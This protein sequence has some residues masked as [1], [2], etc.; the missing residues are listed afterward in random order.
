[1]AQVIIYQNPSAPNVV[2]CYPTGEI[3]ISEVL[4]KDCPPGAIIV[5]DSVLPKGADAEFFDSWRLNGES[6]IVDFNSAKEYKL[7]IYNQ[8]AVAFAQKR[9]L[10]TL[11]GIPND[12]NDV[13]W[14]DKVNAD[15]LAISSATT[16][17][18]LANIAYLQ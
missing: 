15:R 16:T 3:P 6:I 4:I 10:N 14:L 7:K 13:E 11:A 5:D 1:M 17:Q 18:E 8:Y 9:Q 2:V 12:L